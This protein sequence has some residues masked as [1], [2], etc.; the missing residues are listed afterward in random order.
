MPAIDRPGVVPTVCRL[1]VG[2]RGGAKGEMADPADYLADIRR[3]DALADAGVV[4]RIVKHLG[5]ALHRRDSSLVSCLDAKETARIAERWCERKLGVGDRRR[6]ETALRMV[7]E[8]MA[9]DGAKS[10]V[11]FYYLV[12]KHL[13][14]LEAI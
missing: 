10:R 8:T 2:G 14:R 9:A 3:Y 6:S 1:A 11:T 4:E 5:V 7:C 13:G 12:A